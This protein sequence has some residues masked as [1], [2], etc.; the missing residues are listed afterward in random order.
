MIT[1]GIFIQQTIDA[2]RIVFYVAIAL[3]ALE[4]VA[5]T[6]FGSGEEQQWNRIG[7]IPGELQE[8]TPLKGADGE[9]EE[10]NSY[11]VNK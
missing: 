2:W 11:T 3:Y 8:V 7:G 1:N 6:M 10:K 4:A 5:Y 9:G